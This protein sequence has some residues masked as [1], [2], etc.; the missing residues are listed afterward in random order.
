MDLRTIRMEIEKEGIRSPTSDS[1]AKRP[2]AISKNFGSIRAFLANSGADRVAAD[3][4]CVAEEGDRRGEMEKN[5]E[6]EAS[7]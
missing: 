5:G 7:I 2:E 1:A 3:G 4:I 6:E